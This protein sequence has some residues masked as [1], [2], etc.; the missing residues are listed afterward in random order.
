MSTFRVMAIEET[1]EERCFVN[2][3]SQEAA[4]DWID[5]NEDN[6]PEVHFFVER[7]ESLNELLYGRRDY[8]DDWR[9]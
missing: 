6:Y 2:R 5:A 7:E 9:Y 1:G 3:L 4:E 8:D